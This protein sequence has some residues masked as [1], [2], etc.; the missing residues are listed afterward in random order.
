MFAKI[1]SLFSSKFGAVFALIFIGIIA[2]A[3]ALGDVTGSGTFGGVAAGNAAK[4]GDQDVSISE[5]RDMTNNR[6]RTERQRNPN[7]DISQ[8]VE[9]GGLDTTLEQI[10]NRYTLAVF[11]EKHGLGVSQAMVDAE[12]REIPGAKSIDGKFTTESF[13]ALLSRLRI[14]EAAIRKDFTQNLYGQQIFPIANKGVLAPKSMVLPYASLVLERREGQIA[15]IPSAQFLP[16]KPPSDDILS[17]YY[18]ENATQY[19]I[20][21]RR[22]VSYALFSSDI[23]DGDAKV[24]DAEVKTY[25]NDN[26]DEYSASETRSFEQIIVLTK[27]AAEQIIANAKSGLSLQEASKETGLSVTQRSAVSA[28]ELSDSASQAVSDAVFAASVGQYAKPV[29]GSL[30]WYVIKITDIAKKNARTLEQARSEI[31]E[32]VLAEKKSALLSELTSEIED[33]LADGTSLEDIAKERSL[34]VQTSPLLVATGQN[35]EDSSYQ[36]IPEM[37]TIL[38]AAFQMDNDGNGQLIE[39]EQ[40]S[41]FAILTIAQ[42]S[43]AAPPPIDK[44]KDLVTQRWALSQGLAKA[45]VEADKILK[46]VESGTA[47]KKALTDSGLKLPPAQD[48]KASRFEL[49]QQ[50]REVPEALALMFAMPAK[51]IKK[52]EAPGD[53]G[54]ILVNL[55]KITRGDASKQQSLLEET[56]KQF[57]NTIS[58]EHFAQF[59]NAARAEIGVEKSE[60]DIDSL[61]SSLTSV[62]AN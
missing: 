45:K 55:G 2:I 62:I 17:A 11:G 48:L 9:G 27:D 49:T 60:D 8:F 1:R 54:W 47:L 33:A 59:I 43:E 39:I 7:L 42:L 34:K 35:P 58:Q 30:G 51:S 37:A 12:I 31:S 41:K 56:Q 57:K 46:A 32:L 22:S 50:S 52:L 20:P 23:V 61:R 14:S 53:Q 19:I 16:E 21:E 26:K 5:L 3:F 13:R 6:L 40:G 24:T 4:V 15:V 18:K 10:I 25:Y 29:R 36:P 38:P 28:K 44:V